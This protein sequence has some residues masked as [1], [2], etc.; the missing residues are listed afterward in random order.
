MRHRN[1]Y[2]WMIFLAPPLAFTG[3]RT[4]EFWFNVIHRFDIYNIVCE[5]IHLF[6]KI[7]TF[8]SRLIA[9]S[10][11]TEIL[12]SPAGNFI[13]HSDWLRRK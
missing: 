7:I 11:I 4:H 8:W 1:N 5:R 10:Q 6:P 12:T 13:K 2:D 9:R 3:V